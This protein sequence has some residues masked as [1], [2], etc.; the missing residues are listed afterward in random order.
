MASRRN[1]IFNCVVIY[2]P[3]SSHVLFLFSN[4]RVLH[5]SKKKQTNF[6]S[7]YSFAI[8]EFVF[9]PLAKCAPRGGVE[10]NYAAEG[11]DFS[12]YR[13]NLLRGGSYSTDARTRNIYIWKRAEG[14]EKT[15]RRSVYARVLPVGNKFPII[16]RDCRRRLKG[17]RRR[18]RL[19]GYV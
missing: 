16:C 19:R 13:V 9:F 4:I 17:G 11:S 14:G 5:F 1:A 15:L 7:L 2:N 3:L 10:S 12:Y 6:E 8:L 18:R